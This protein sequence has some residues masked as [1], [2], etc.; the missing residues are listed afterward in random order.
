MKYRYLGPTKVLCLYWHS[1]QLTLHLHFIM[2][3]S[4]RCQKAPKK[5]IQICCY[6]I[7]ISPHADKP[8]LG[9]G[10]STPQTSLTVTMT[11]AISS[12]YFFVLLPNLVSMCTRPWNFQL[13]FSTVFFVMVYLS[14]FHTPYDNYSIVTFK[15]LGWNSLYE[16]PYFLTNI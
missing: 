5:F 13:P 12:F 2:L 14:C 8:F 9:F 6:V 1:H 3:T 10:W 7:V 4:E 15:I 16:N 11:F